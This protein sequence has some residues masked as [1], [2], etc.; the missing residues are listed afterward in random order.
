M[1][2]PADE[3]AEIIISD[4]RG[5]L[6]DALY[7]LASPPDVSGATCQIHCAIRRLND[8]EGEIRHMEIAMDTLKAMVEKGKSN[9]NK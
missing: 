8:L 3:M 4:A 5:C 1:R 7:Y 6:K 9:D 2:L